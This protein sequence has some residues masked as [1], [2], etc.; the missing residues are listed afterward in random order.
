MNLE[1]SNAITRSHVGKIMIKLQ[2]Q[3]KD[4][5]AKSP[6]EKITRSMK[7][8]LMATESLK[9][10]NADWLEGARFWH[11]NNFWFYDNR[12]ASFT[13]SV[14][15]FFTPFV[16]KA[17]L[18]ALSL[19]NLICQAFYL[20]IWNTLGEKGVVKV[21]H[22]GAFRSVAYF[23]P[24]YL[25]ACSRKLSSVRKFSFNLINIIGVNSLLN[26]RV[27]LPVKNRIAMAQKFEVPAMESQ[28]QEI[29]QNLNK[30]YLLPPR[31][32]SMKPWSI[33]L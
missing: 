9:S 18:G 19:N 7:M 5:I 30:S 16:L 21:D 26:P 33:L 22:F 29:H 28:S 10:T 17:H 11:P 6:H 14:G 24:L 12:P 8:L 3:L 13:F 23:C 25:S 1:P 27:L 31:E 4:F 32:I 20:Y 15:A 2:T